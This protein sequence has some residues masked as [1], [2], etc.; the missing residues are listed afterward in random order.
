MKRMFEAMV[1]KW[2][3][4]S[5]LDRL[6]TDD[7]RRKKIQLTNQEKK[8]Q[9]E[10]EGTEKAK[11]RLFEQASAKDVSDRQRMQTAQKIV[12]LD[13]RLKELDG[14]W[15]RLCKDQKI[16]EGL[17]RIKEEKLNA[18]PGAIS[19]DVDPEEIR[20]WI[21]KNLVEIQM[22]NEKADQILDLLN[23]DIYS[24]TSLQMTEAEK[25]IYE[26]LRKQA[27][28]TLEVP[29]TDETGS[30]ELESDRRNQNESF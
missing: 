8:L 13:R 12:D 27:D 23:N 14:R 19:I 7:L 20:E 2:W 4:K 5:S 1:G 26:Q 18:T 10:I 6:N 3:S 17:I 9:T 28:A 25:A 11:I 29:T 22:A 21:E 16:V 30:S 24:E 15:V